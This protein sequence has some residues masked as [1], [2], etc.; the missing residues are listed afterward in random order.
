MRLFMSD[1][2][3]KL[4]IWFIAVRGYSFPISIMSWVVPFIFSFLKGGNVFYGILALVAIVLLHA[5]SNIFDDVVDYYMEKRSIDKGLKQN[6]NFQKNKCACIFDGSLTFKEYC[7]ASFILFLIPLLIGLYF[8]L[9]YGTGLLPIIIITAI[10]CLLYPILG[11]LGLG[12]VIVAVV[13]SPLL[14]LGVSYVMT[15]VY[16]IDVLL[17]S[18]STGLLTVSVLHN[19]MLL[20]FKFDEKNRKIT[21][22]RLCKT[23]KRALYLLCFIIL[24]SYLNIIISVIF[25][26]L[27]PI[28]L[29]TLLSLPTAITLYNVMSMHIENSETEIKP[30]LFMGNIREIYN[31]PVEQRGFLIKFLIVRNLL[32]IF[33][34]LICISIVLDKL[35]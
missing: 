32:S 17:I 35:L 29:I 6:F 22:C 11:S 12:E 24:A 30:T 25:R 20:D 14:Y 33:T 7:F 4:S 18:I 21:L 8:V 28:Y 10:L 13:F 19:H 16:T 3:R 34:L 15:G 23:Q 31:V 1:F 26:L 2:C 27:S 5:G 9:I